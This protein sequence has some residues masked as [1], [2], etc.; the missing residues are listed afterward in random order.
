[1]LDLFKK[2]SPKEIIVGWYSTGAEINETSVLLHDFFAKEMNGLPVHLIVNTNFSERKME[3]QTYLSSNITI[4]DKP[5]GS[6]FISLPHELYS[7]D[8]GILKNN[9]IGAKLI[10]S[11]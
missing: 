6:Q 10:C 8:Q 11:S 7:A 4:N 3:I 9:L 2:V 5:L 1:M